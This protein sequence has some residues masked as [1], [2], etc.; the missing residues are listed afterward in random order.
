MRIGSLRHRVTL[1]NPVETR[2]DSGEISVEWQDWQTVWASVEPIGGREFF[3]AAQLQAE[4]D[5]RIRLR[6]IA[7]LTP[8][9]RAKHVTL[10]GSP[11]LIALY[12]VEAVVSLNERGREVHLMCKRRDGHGFK[13]VGASGE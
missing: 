13:A 12:S 5:A 2:L 10:G 8:R 6:W 9:M 1:Q 4:I 3:A 11:S 7:G